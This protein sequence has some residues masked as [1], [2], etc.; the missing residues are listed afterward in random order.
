M[1]SCR[2]EIPR[3][4]QNPLLI[5]S[6]AKKEL[7]TFVH[8]SLKTNGRTRGAPVPILFHVSCLKRLIA[9]RASTRMTTLDLDTTTSVVRFDVAHRVQLKTHV[10]LASGPSSQR[11]SHG[12]AVNQLDQ[13]LAVRLSVAA[14]SQ[15]IL[16]F[17]LSLCQFSDSPAVFK[18]FFIFIPRSHLSPHSVQGSNS[19]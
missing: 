17:K 11:S 14:A 6:R 12:P 7:C 16:T 13:G 4:T 18:S 19:F 3:R 9:S 15:G 2:R 1:S 10:P 8:C 5:R